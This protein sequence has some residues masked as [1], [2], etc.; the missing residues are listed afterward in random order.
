MCAPHRYG[1]GVNELVRFEPEAREPSLRIWDRI[2]NDL[3]EPLGER[4]YPRPSQAAEARIRQLEAA[5]ARRQ[6]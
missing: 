5:L 3:V 4:L 2:E 1:C 6:R